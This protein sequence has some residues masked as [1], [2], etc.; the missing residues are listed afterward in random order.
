MISSIIEKFNLKNKGWWQGEIEGVI[1]MFPSNFVKEGDDQC[2]SSYA[3]EEGPGHSQIKAIY[4]YTAQ[5][6]SELSFVV[7]EIFSFDSEEEGWYYV[8]NSKNEYG[9]IPSNYVQNV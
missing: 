4:D 9:R 7:G 5:D 6:S 3:E 8:Y 2:T 1:G